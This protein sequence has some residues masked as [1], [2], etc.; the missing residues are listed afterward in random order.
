MSFLKGLAFHSMLVSFGCGIIFA[1]EKY[2]EKNDKKKR[3]DP[4]KFL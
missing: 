3:N 4:T 1:A 2:H